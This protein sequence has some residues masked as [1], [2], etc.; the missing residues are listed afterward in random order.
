MCGVKSG[1]R[2]GAG[3]DLGSEVDGLGSETA[4]G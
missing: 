2:G 3:V 4:R 1:I